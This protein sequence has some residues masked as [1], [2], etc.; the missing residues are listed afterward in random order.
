MSNCRA[1]SQAVLLI[2]VAGLSACGTK[3][4]APGQSLVKVNGQEITVHQVNEE[5]MRGNVPAA[6]RDAA[7]K[8]LIEALIDRQLLQGEAMRDKVDRDP[9][10]MQ[11]IERAKSQIIA[12]AYIQKRLAKVS[13]PTKDEIQAYFDAHP[14][15]F[16]QRKVFEMNQLIIA[17]KDLSDDLKVMLGNAKSSTEVSTWLDAHHIG[18]LRNQM[19]KNSAELPA[20]LT[21]KMLALHKGQMMVVQEGD[22]DVLVSLNDVK[23]SPVT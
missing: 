20:E 18:Y 12:Q 23:D 8:Q 9:A 2:A 22:R 21:K 10:V 19:A 7:T 13:K 5:L 6:Q 4:K 17:G 16:A 11:A 14:E 1:L 3:D 15:F